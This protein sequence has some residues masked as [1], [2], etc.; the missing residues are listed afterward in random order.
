MCHVVPRGIAYLFY[1]ILFIYL[2]YYLLIYLLIYSF[3]ILLIYLCHVVTRGTN[4]EPCGIPTAHAR[5]VGLIKNAK[6]AIFE[7]LQTTNE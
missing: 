3:F 1:S 7:D 2:F 6:S 5:E 4:K